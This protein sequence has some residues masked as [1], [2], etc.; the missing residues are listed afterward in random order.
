MLT[1]LFSPWGIPASFRH[2][3]GSGV[4]TYKW[5]NA[6]GVAHLVK[7]HWVPH[8][9]IKNLTQA[10]ADKLQ[11]QNFNNATQDLYDAIAR[12]EFPSWELNVQIMEDHEHPE[13]DFDPLD[14]TKLWPKDQFPWL[15]VGKMTLNR[16]PV[17]Y[18]AEVEQAAFGTGVLV[19]GLEFSDDKMLV[20][21]TF[22]YSDTQRYRV[23]PNYLQLPINAPKCKVATNQQNGPMTFQVEGVVAG[24]NPHVNYEPSSRGGPLQQPPNAIGGKPHEPVYERAA[25]QRKAIERTNCFKQAGA[26][27]R[28]LKDWEKNDLISN[29]VGALKGCN[30]DI[31]ERMIHNFTQADPEYGARVAKGINGGAN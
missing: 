12:D 4:N 21:R 30:K 17:N 23:G 16:N 22:S 25:V 2:M 31:Q 9:E 1:W 26:T 5:V 19:D 27:Y 15:P 20:G 11:G 14:D 28:Q 10:E 18:F 24:G 7:Y 8:Q 13:L 3:E 29:L 6:D